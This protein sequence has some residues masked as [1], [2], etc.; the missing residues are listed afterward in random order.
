MNGL[1]NI[2]KPPNATSFDIVSFIRKKL[3][4]KKVG[5]SG[6]L[7]PMAVGV[8]PIC[9]GKGTKLINYMQYD[10]KTYRCELTLGANTDTQ[11]IWGEVIEEFDTAHITDDMIV[12]TFKSFVG[13]QTQIPPMYS[14]LKVNG[15][16]L[17]ELAREGIEIERKPRDIQIYRLDII[18]ID[19]TR[20][21]FDAEVSKGTYI[22]TLCYDIGKT[23]NTG[24]FMSFLSRTEC[25]VFSLENTV[26]VEEIMESTIDEIKEKYLI[27]LDY[28][29]DDMP[30]VE[31]HPFA[32]RFLINGV[33]VKEQG[34]LS[35]P[36]IKDNDLIRVYVDDEFYAI[37]KYRN[38]DK[39]QGDI[40]VVTLFKN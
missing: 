18:N 35:K 14:A 16:K 36:D 26:T 20:I 34:I 1:I 23:L 17:Y 25:G 5:H 15:R 31:I 12:D 38:N 6:T 28:P 4:I 39:H 22:R 37:G 2:L 19:K 27:G 40:K 32:K 33:P 11:D 24:G 29:I 30:R 7:D 21:I 10:S 3:N 13:K 8:L 9:I